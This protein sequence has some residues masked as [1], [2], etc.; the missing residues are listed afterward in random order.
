ME[1]E[2][3][4]ESEEPSCED[5][6]KEQGARRGSEE[7]SCEDTAEEQCKQEQSSEEKDSTVYESIQCYLSKGSYPQNSTKAEKGVI[8]RWAKSFSLVDG[9][10]H[11]K[12]SK[13]HIILFLSS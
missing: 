7:P 12:G 5:I 2:A 1:Q 10:L 13:G 8:R 6:A 11:Y 4:I 3:R 9:I